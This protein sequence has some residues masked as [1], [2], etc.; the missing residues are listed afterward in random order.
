MQNEKEEEMSKGD[1]EETLISEGLLRPPAPRKPRAKR[2]KSTLAS[3][4]RRQRE[5]Q[6]SREM[7]LASPLGGSNK[8]DGSGGSGVTSE[9]GSEE[10]TAPAVP[11]QASFSA[12]IATFEPPF[13]RQV[14][15]SRSLPDPQ[16]LSEAGFF[17]LEGSEG[18]DRDSVRCFQC[19]VVQFS[20]EPS[21][22]P[23]LRHQKSSPMC[24]FVQGK[25]KGQGTDN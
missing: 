22:D 1:S 3:Q 20:W 2:K 14:P 9:T 21:E 7:S 18:G 24:V 13:A 8:E 10:D 23:W 16:R 19:G 12:R 4:W 17:L 5:L 6:R 25:M 15:P 11:E